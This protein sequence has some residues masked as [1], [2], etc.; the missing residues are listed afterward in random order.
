MSTKHTGNRLELKDENNLTSEVIY[1]TDQKTVHIGRSEQNTISIRQ[2]WVSR[3]HAMIQR[4]STGTYTIIDL[5]SSNGTSVNQK[6]IVTPRI[7]HSGD[8]I[9][10]GRT[11]LV[12]YQDE[13]QIKTNM[14]DF[15]DIEEQTVACIDK[16]HVTVLVS[17][18]HNFT[19]M[20]ETLG[21]RLISRLLQQWSSQVRKIVKQNDGM[22]DKFLGDGVM[23]L[24]IADPKNSLQKALGAS[25]AIEKMTRTLHQHIDGIPTKLTTGAALNTG[26]A[27]AGNI[28]GRRDFTVIGDAVNI[29]FRLEDM[30]ST[31]GFD[32]LIGGDAVAILPSLQPYCKQRH[33]LLKGKGEKVTAYGTSFSNLASFMGSLS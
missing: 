18:I 10:I 8:T 11:H 1:L 32:L 23:A 21:D 13:G 25:L 19:S 20:A 2:S 12:F 33:F 14:P 4:D 30:T 16:Q 27:I 6:R 31:S 7:L 28:G 22:V 29:V 3:Q 5:G 15:S 17:D 24:W 9:G 26:E